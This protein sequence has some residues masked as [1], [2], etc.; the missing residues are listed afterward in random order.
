MELSQKERLTE[1]QIAILQTELMKSQRQVGFA[2]VLTLIGGFFGLH[3][4]YLEKTGQA[5]LYLFLG[6]VV[7]LSGVI[8]LS[9][10]GLIGFF[11]GSSRAAEAM[12][13]SSVLSFICLIILICLIIYDL[14]TLP[15]QVK[16]FN[17]ELEEKIVMALPS[18]KPDQNTPAA[19][20]DDGNQSMGQ[21]KG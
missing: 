6:L 11:M 9:V 15:E 2:Y 5:G 8:M 18:T 21:S 10:G 16:R 20:D 19:A 12:G 4:L 14:F 17:D 7:I 13:F 1:K 3:K